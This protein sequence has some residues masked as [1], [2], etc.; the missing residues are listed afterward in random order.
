M[1]LESSEA[2]AWYTSIEPPCSLHRPTAESSTVLGLIAM[3]HNSHDD[4]LV[5]S[6]CT[7]LFTLHQTAQQI[8]WITIPKEVLNLM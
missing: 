2:S 6:F 7:I 4:Q 3:V 1:H 8:I 5:P